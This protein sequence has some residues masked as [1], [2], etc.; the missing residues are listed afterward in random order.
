MRAD[1]RCLLQQLA[2]SESRHFSWDNFLANTMAY[3]SLPLI[4][5]TMAVVLPSGGS[6][7]GRILFFLSIPSFWLDDII[8]MSPVL[9]TDAVLTSLDS[10]AVVVGV[11]FIGLG[12]V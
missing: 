1:R 10:L 4:T 12:G 9:L 7:L 11:A 6:F 5:A 3:D 2:F 8:M